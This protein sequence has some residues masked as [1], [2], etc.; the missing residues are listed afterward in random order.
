VTGH[1]ANLSDGRVR[2]VVEGGQQAVERFL[3][4]L[5][6][7]LRRYIAA[8]DVQWSDASGEFDSFEI[9]NYRAR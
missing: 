3:D 1:V 8:A 6:A 7:R 9:R 5:A 2:L 4:D